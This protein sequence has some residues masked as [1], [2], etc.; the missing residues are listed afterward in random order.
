MIYP[1]QK[2]KVPVN[3]AE[4]IKR[5]IIEKGGIEVK[6]IKGQY[7]VWR[8]KFSDATLTYYKTETLY[9][10]P[11]GDPAIERIHDLIYGK[12]NSIFVKPNKE[13]LIGFD[14]AGKGEVLGHE[15]LAGVI[16]PSTLYEKLERVVSVA[17]TKRKR[18]IEYWDKILKFIDNFRNEGLNFQVQ[19]IP[20]WVI[21]RFNLNKIMDIT[22]QR[23]LSIFIRNVNPSKC[24]IV[25]DDYRIGSSLRTYLK[26]LENIGANVIVATNADNNYLEARVASLIAKREREKVIEAINKS[27]NMNGMNVGSGNARD[28][29]T[30]KW[31]K[32]WKKNGKEWPWFVK[33]S[34]RTVRELDGLPKAKKISPPI[35]E[36]ILSRNFIKK[37]NKGKYS[38]ETLT[39]VC[40][41]CGEVSRAVQMTIDK[42]NGKLRTS[43]RCI[44]CGKPIPNLDFTLRYYCGY[45]MPDSNIIIG[46]FLSKDL[47]NSKFFEDFTIVL[48]PIVKYET[49]KSRG[50]RKELE[51]IANF[52]ARGR[53]RLEEVKSNLRIENMS[54]QERDEKII[55]WAKEKN[56]IL[57][58]ADNPMKTFAQA[59]NMFC[60]YV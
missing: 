20:P 57:I 33:K 26:S 32:K 18:T 12:V 19:K 50:G 16:F 59:K 37:F 30:I 51:R 47:S 25:I 3:K 14:E 13:I 11:S 56:A 41:Y 43:G 8:I 42:S 31:L 40:P 46:G 34:F 15:V 4:E 27:F 55:E 29:R 9:C 17:N 52:A 48:N 24:R 36:S 44:K 21:D 53:I 35:N 23:M 38:I 1:G 54:S 39:I 60:L 5:L 49:D 28:M 7:E 6:E 2:W 22:Y 10:T 45:L 58:T